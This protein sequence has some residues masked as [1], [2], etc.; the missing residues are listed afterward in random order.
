[1]NKSKGFFIS[2]KE[3][4]HKCDKSQ[5]DEAGFWEKIKL[6]LHLIYC[7][8]CRKYSANNAKL[9]KL[10][11]KDEVDCMDVNEKEILKSEFKKEMTK[12]N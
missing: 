2:C 7:R 5:Y 4:N 12:Y 8:A 3:A 1:M 10:I 9:T 11:K 6:S